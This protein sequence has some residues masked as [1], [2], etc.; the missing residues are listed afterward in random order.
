MSLFL[1]DTAIY[2]GEPRDG[3]QLRVCAET[4]NASR[5]ITIGVVKDGFPVAPRKGSQMADFCEQLT[6]G[7]CHASWMKPHG[8]FGPERT[9]RGVSLVTLDCSDTDR[10]MDLI[11][12]ANAVVQA[13]VVHR[14]EI[15]A[16]HEQVYGKPTIR[17]TKEQDAQAMASALIASDPLVAQV[18]NVD[19]LAAYLVKSSYLGS[20]PDKQHGAAVHF[21]ALECNKVAGDDAAF[22]QTQDARKAIEAAA[23]S[24]AA[25][26]AARG[27]N[28]HLGR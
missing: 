19:A 6:E 23:L 17:T 20:D 3:L 11:A 5:K 26:Q 10:D 12:Q 28:Q 15:Q 7:L 8:R 21:V 9:K 14:N 1:R 22:S 2:E 13:L 4:T 24:F 16:I 25:A 27:S 18:T